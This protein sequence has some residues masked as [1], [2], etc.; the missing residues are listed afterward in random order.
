MNSKKTGDNINTCV[1]IHYANFALVPPKLK[2]RE[3]VHVCMVV[4]SAET[5]S[6]E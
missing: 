6:T 3:V 1:C 2:H 5:L 4:D